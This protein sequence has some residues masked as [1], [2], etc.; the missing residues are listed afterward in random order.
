VLGQIK[1]LYTNFVAWTG[2]D[3]YIVL[4]GHSKGGMV[5]RYLMSAPTGNVGNVNLTD[6]QEADCKFL[7]DKCKYIVTLGTPHDGSP[8]AEAGVDILHKLDDTQAAFQGFWTAT[9]NTLATVGVTLPRTPPLNLNGVKAIIGSEAELADL[10]SAAT[11]GFN[12]GELKPT[13]MKRSDG[14]PIP[15]YCYAG[16]SP[17]DR[18]FAT[19]RHDGGGGPSLAELTTTEGKSAMG[20]CTL[21]WALHN[22]GERDWGTM[23]SVGPGKSLDLVRR[24]YS[25]T[26]IKPQALPPFFK[27]VKRFSNPF[28]A[29]EIPLTDFAFEGMPIYFQRNA[30]DSETDNDGM[31]PAS[32]ALAVTLSV[33]G[34]EPYDHTQPGGQIYRMYGTASSPWAFCNH[35]TLSNTKPMGDEVRRLLISAGPKVSTRALSTF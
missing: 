26:E 3:P 4:V 12:T 16:R 2:S 21:D 31:V 20:L 18:F 33:V 11:V 14:S 23:T 19:P 13:Q 6:D 24:T 27:V 5:A 25:I 1:T 10:T 7:R 17:G 29:F 28:E 35:R 30:H 15:M 34:T 32:S 8:L 22:V 9:R